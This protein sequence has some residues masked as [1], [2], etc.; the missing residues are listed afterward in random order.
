MYW[1]SFLFG[2]D[3]FGP[4]RGSV[5]ERVRLARLAPGFGAGPR[6]SAALTN[7]ARAVASNSLRGCFFSPL[8]L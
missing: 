2:R 4:H 8:R 6:H 5:G 1:N 3:L 7:R